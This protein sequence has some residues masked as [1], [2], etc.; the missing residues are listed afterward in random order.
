VAVAVACGV[1][2]TGVA[3]VLSGHAAIRP[4][5]K[6]SPASGAYWGIYS[7]TPIATREAQVGRKFA[8]HQKFYDWANTFPGASE[9][10][11]VANG[12]IPLATWQPQTNGATPLSTNTNADIAAGVFDTTIN[13]RA[14]AMR[15]FGHP[16]F[17]RFAPE[18]NGNW[19]K[20]SPANNGSTPDPAAF[21]AAWRHVHDLFV[22]NGATNVVWVWCPNAT[23]VPNATSAPWNHWTN[24]Y[25]GDTYVD[26]VGIDGYNWGNTTAGI[27]WQSFAGIFGNGTSGVYADY[28]ATKPIVI[29]ET[30]SAFDGAPTGTSKAQWI[31]DMAAA[32]QSKFPSVEAIV[33]FDTVSSTGTREWPIDTDPASL[34]A[35]TADGQLSYFIPNAK[36][37]LFAFLYSS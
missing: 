34:A 9:A 32:I 7:S 12:R 8:V 19:E 2:I 10:D 4:A 18:M 35:Y 14:E 15:A 21:V 31:S 24:Y 11:D 29:A 30:G 33:Y 13:T 6:L 17:L 20:W 36:L 22:Q 3:A 27:S 5:G 25:P 1:L 16:I 23:D 37:S 26:W 28:A